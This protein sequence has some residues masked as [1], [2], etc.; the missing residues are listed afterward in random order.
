ME[1]LLRR[2]GHRYLAIAEAVGVDG[3]TVRNDAKVGG[4]DPSTPQIKAKSTGLDGKPTR[5]PGHIRKRPVTRLHPLFVFSQLPV[6][7]D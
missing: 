4:A 6:A 2:A 3:K 7:G 1:L 5:P